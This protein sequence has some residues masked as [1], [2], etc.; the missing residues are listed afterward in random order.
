MTREYDE[1]NRARSRASSAS[2]HDADVRGWTDHEAPLLRPEQ[3][4]T[5]GLVERRGNTL[6]SVGPSGLASVP[7]AATQ[8]LQTA[9]VLRMVG[10]HAA[11]SA[12][13][14]E[15]SS[16]S[17][18]RVEIPAVLHFIWMG[19]PPT[20]AAVKNIL[21]WAAR[22]KNT[23]WR[24]ILWSD[25]AIQTGKWAPQLAALRGSVEVRQIR[26]V[27]DPRLR[28]HYLDAVDKTPRAFNVAS[29][30]ARYSILHQ[31]GGV[32]ADV[33]LGPGDVDLSRVPKLSTADLPVTAPQVRDRQ[34]LEEQLGPEELGM[35]STQE[36][37][38]MAAQRAYRKNQL[39][40]NLLISG[41]QSTFMNRLIDNVHRRVAAREDERDEWGDIAAVM[42]GPQPLI[43]TMHEHL[44]GVS[45]RRLIDSMD[46]D[47]LGHWS[48]LD[49][50]TEESENQ[51]YDVA[52][53][54][55]SK[56]GWWSQWSARR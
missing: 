11:T 44:G 50:L 30:L 31:L 36:A 6:A 27:I 39:N 56:G 38:Q 53:G 7:T 3:P 9:Q 28:Q 2:A 43:R 49:W 19:K 52:S 1:E 55:T 40:N 17:A 21:A 32:Y 12:S 22:A 35:L 33:D 25:D 29:D 14:T 41:P 45:E 26:P 13:E 24:I 48:R 18:D 10:G 34:S 42:S 46:R 47:T 15:A 16:P 8:D 54:S 20:D 37:A 5:S 4:I 51:N 23:S